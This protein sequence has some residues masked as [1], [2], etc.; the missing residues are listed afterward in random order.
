MIDRQ[1]T[2]R[3]GRRVRGIDDRHDDI[4]TRG[5]LQ[6]SQGNATITFRQRAPH[7]ASQA[8]RSFGVLPRRFS[9][10]SSRQDS[11][12]RS[13]DSRQQSV[14]STSQPVLPQTL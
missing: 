9:A 1:R 6:H 4:G 11:R 10:R 13:R 3:L 14:V 5:R 7:A 12:R 2:L 8:C